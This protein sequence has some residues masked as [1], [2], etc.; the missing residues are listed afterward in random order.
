MLSFDHHILS[1]SPALV[2]EA[3]INDY[4]DNDVQNKTT[5]LMTY[6]LA[7]IVIVWVAF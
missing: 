2:R 5:I 7:Y 4:R 6:I 1:K 3:F